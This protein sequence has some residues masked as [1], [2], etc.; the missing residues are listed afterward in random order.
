MKREVPVPKGPKNC[1]MGQKV[2]SFYR[3]KKK[4][5]SIEPKVSMAFGDWLPEHTVS[6]GTFTGT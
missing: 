6:G 3:I 2:G 5:I 4:E 1:K